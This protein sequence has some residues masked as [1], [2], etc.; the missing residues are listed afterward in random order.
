MVDVADT[1]TLTVADV[2]AIEKSWT[3]TVKVAVVEWDNVPL[4]PVI[5]TV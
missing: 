4:V 3:P 1:P 2:A 5:V